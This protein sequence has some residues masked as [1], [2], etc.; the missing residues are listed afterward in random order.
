MIQKGKNTPNNK[1]VYKVS[2]DDLPLHCPLPSMR[3]WDSHP[4]VFLPIQKTKEG[5]IKC[6]YCG[7]D[8]VLTPNA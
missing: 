7:T 2:V 4:R 3:L 1:Q 5:R 6:P 8:Y